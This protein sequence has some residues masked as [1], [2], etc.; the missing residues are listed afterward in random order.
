[1]LFV[2]LKH[3]VNHK[4]N[5]RT[6]ITFYQAIIFFISIGNIAEEEEE[7]VFLLKNCFVAKLDK[8]CQYIVMQLNR[9]G[10]K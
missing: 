3:G 10:W 9:Y 7:H 4:M 5:H 6:R 1:M 2:F 8:I